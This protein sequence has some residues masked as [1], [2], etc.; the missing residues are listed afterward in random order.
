MYTLSARPTIQ[1]DIPDDDGYDDAEDDG[2]IDVGSVK[3]MTMI[4]VD[5]VI[6]IARDNIF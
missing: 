6:V 5:V 3:R 1:Y 4:G 2:R